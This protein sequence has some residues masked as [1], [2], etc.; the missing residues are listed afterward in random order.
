M[1]HHTP[2]YLPH[3]TPVNRTLII[4]LAAAFLL[5]SVLGAGL[6]WSLGYLTGLRGEAFWGG[7]IH[8]LVTWPLVPGSPFEA[9]FDGLILWFIGSELE[10]MW[11]RRRYI[12][13]LGA[14]ILSGGVAFLLVGFTGIYPAVLSGMGGVTSAVCLAFGLLFPRRVMFFLFFPLR[15]K[16]LVMILVGMNLYQGLFSPGKALAWGILGS[17]LGAFL[18]MRWEWLGRKFS[19]PKKW[20]HLRPVDDKIEGESDKKITYH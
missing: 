6:G 19:R 14:A 10:V 15:A 13:F 11:G 12:G 8:Q 2:I 4:A 16:Y 3:L 20:R 5:D 7:H 17:C 1:R 18:W 9:L